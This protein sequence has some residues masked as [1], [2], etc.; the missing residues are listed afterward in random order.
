MDDTNKAAYTNSKIKSGKIFASLKNTEE[1][2]GWRV[3][4]GEGII[5][6]RQQ[7]IP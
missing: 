5:L 4:K 3:R 2:G 1:V 7:T 6:K